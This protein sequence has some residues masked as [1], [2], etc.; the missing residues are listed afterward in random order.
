V[1]ANSE[2]GD[3]PSVSAYSTDGSDFSPIP[4]LSLTVG[5]VSFTFTA[6][7]SLEIGRK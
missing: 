3:L 6:E 2:T 7:L 5:F 4:D 1:A